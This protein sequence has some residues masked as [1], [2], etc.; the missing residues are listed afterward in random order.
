[1]Q[2]CF[3]SYIPDNSGTCSLS[4]SLSLLYFISLLLPATSSPFLIRELLIFQ[5]HWLL[6]FL[7]GGS[8]QTEAFTFL[9]QRNL[10]LQTLRFICRCKLRITPITQFQHTMHYIRLRHY[11]F[12]LQLWGSC[13]TCSTYSKLLIRK[14]LPT[15]CL[16][17]RLRHYILF[18]FFF[19]FL[20]FYCFGMD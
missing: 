3:V 16:S 18:F 7:V 12:L 8:E 15:S 19:F 5:C 6:H 2:P 4:P 1:M 17:Q 10:I 14:V 13:C 9:S 11:I 20:S